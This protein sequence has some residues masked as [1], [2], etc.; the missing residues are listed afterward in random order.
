MS[1]LGI[2]SETAA[3][4]LAGYNHGFRTVFILN[5]SLAAFA[6]VVSI[7]MIKHKSLKRGDE[8]QLKKEALDQEQQ[9]GVG[10]NTDIELGDI[11]RVAS[12][13]EE[14]KC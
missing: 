3:E 4:I 9:V 2:S 14:E 5:A 10:A 6:T 13:K 11:T 1:S 12:R 7:F 8:D